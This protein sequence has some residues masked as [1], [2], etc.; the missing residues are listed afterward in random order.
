MVK[1]EPDDEGMIEVP[2]R[3]THELCFQHRVHNG[4]R[5]VA[6][7]NAFHVTHQPN[8][9]FSTAER[10]AREAGVTSEESNT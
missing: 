5:V 6:I 2:R 1:V 3:M 10:H 4:G 8:D 7:L 9:R